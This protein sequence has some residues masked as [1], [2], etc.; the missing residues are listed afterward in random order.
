VVAEVNPLSLG[1]GKGCNEY[2]D[3]H[4]GN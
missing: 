3:S 4:T 1:T 2:R